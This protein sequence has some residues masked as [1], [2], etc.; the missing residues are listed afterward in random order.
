MN[1]T[2][3]WG[4]C[5]VEFVYMLMGF[6][7]PQTQPEQKATADS[8]GPPVVRKEAPASEALGPFVED[9]STAFLRADWT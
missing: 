7:A 3:K 8:Q 1:N 9:E 2:R 5:A 6:A 4:S